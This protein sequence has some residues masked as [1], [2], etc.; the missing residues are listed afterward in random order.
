MVHRLELRQSD[1]T[2]DLTQK[3]LVTYICS[4]YGHKGYF[5]SL[6]T[7]KITVLVDHTRSRDIFVIIVVSSPL[8]GDDKILTIF[9]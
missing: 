5:C 1:I 4:T 6:E 3:F 2:L 7:A 8:I 9:S